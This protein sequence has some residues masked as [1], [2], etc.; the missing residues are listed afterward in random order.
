MRARTLIEGAI[1]GGDTIR[2]FGENFGPIP[3]GSLRV[4]D[5][6]DHLEQKPTDN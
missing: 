3:P 6:D 4:F 5:S 1:A 2:T